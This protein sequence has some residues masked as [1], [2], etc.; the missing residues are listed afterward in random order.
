[1]YN[2]SVKRIRLLPVLL[3]S[4]IIFFAVGFT[5]TTQAA[6]SEPSPTPAKQMQ[7]A[8]FNVYN[9]PGYYKHSGYYNHSGYHKYPGR[10]WGPWRNRYY[11]PTLYWSNW[12]PYYYRHGYRCQKSCLINSW[13]G[14]IIRC[15]KRCF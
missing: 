3:T 7:L 9:K 14:M 5:A 4:F 12:Y 6:T 15:Q 2:S 8:Y 10:Y 11:Q 1:M 13:N